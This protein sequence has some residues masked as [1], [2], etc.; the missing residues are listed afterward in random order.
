M[1]ETSKQKVYDVIIIGGGPAGAAT[2]IQLKR[3]GVRSVLIVEKGCYAEHRIGESLPPNANVLL[4]D[5]GVY[6][7]FQKE[8]HLQ[9]CGSCSIWGSDE[10]GYNDYIVSP[11]GLGWHL[12]RNK[13]D[14][15]L[16]DQACQL[17]AILQTE[18]RFVKSVPNHSISGYS[19]ELKSK[20]GLAQQVHA[21]FV[22]DASGMQ[23]VFARKMSPSKKIV[24]RL[25]CVS[26]FFEIPKDV[27]LTSQTLLEAVE[28]GWWYLATLPGHRVIAALAT[29]PEVVNHY[30]LSKPEH[31]MALLSHVQLLPPSIRP[32]LR[33]REKLLVSPALS[34]HLT[35]PGGN[36]WLAVGD[37]ASCY[38][39]ISSLGIFKCMLTGMEAGK[40]IFAYL[41]S[42]EDQIKSY[43]QFLEADYKKYKAS[44]DHFYNI[45]NR[46]PGSPFWNRRKMNA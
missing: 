16:A 39:P 8:G 19:L 41:N 31:W 9:V 6:E 3:L 33:L 22:V 21:R 46:W 5:L 38:D 44:R 43:M 30:Q 10:P 17:G 15:F 2:A 1:T 27:P 23:A 12:D 37:A 32:Y 28:Y 14:R 4:K 42:H 11:F 29:D 25:I 40:V 24:D 36:N 20:G 34:S 35:Q 26:G 18:T 13:F 45:E 7:A